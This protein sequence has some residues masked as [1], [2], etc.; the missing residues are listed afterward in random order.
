MG[1]GHGLPGYFN[2]GRQEEMCLRRCFYRISCNVSMMA[3]MVF[4]EEREGEGV[5]L[6]SCIEPLHRQDLF[7]GGHPICCVEVRSQL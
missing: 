7:L 5:Q 3:A 1:D 6:G 4:L 2:E